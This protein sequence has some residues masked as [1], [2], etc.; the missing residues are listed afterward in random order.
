MTM[1]TILLIEDHP[2]VRENTA[3]FLELA[4]YK[5]LTAENGKAGLELALREIPDLILCDVM[6]PVLDGFGVYL[7]LNK[8]LLTAGIPFIFLTA[9]TEITAQK[10]G[11]NLGADDYVTKPFDPDL[12]LTIIKT[13]IE[14]QDRAKEEIEQEQ[15]NYLR[16][17]EDMLNFTSHQVRAPLC[18][19]Q[20]L[21]PLLEK[22]T[23][24]ANTAE[25]KKILS[26]MNAS[27]KDL[28]N[29]T[30]ELTRFLS[31]AG[32][33]KKTKLGIIKPWKKTEE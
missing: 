21:I 7:A 10:Y 18:N 30:Q 8:N 33:K 25:V 27:I 31:E 12:L 5:V 17:L 14:K 11:I 4:N 1:K 6:M 26:L 29:F 2:D 32:E 15:L 20:G 28:D 24:Q 13:R 22:Y 3:E 16:E 9:R 23:E 19:C